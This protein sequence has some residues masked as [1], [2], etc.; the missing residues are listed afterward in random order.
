M[1]WKLKKCRD[2]K[3]VLYKVK[4]ASAF[5]GTMNRDV[6]DYCYWRTGSYCSTDKG[7]HNALLCSILLH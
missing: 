7:R 3:S 2:W 4:S 1:N 5:N 6:I